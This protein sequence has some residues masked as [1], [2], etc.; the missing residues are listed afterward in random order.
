MDAELT[1]AQLDDMIWED[2]AWKVDNM[3]GDGW[4]LR[5]IAAVPGMP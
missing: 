1:P 2:G 5:Q 3:R 4:D